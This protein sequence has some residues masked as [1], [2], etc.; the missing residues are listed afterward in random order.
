MEIGTTA[1]NV[2]TAD[3]GEVDP[4]NAGTFRAMSPGPSWPQALLEVFLCSGVP[5]QLLV[6][7]ALALAGLRP[8]GDGRFTLQLLAVLTGLDTVLLI[9]LV[10]SLLVLGGESPRR[11]L[12]GTRPILG[13][14]VRGLALVPWVFL[15]AAAVV[16][17]ISR[18]APWLVSPNPFETLARTRG[19]FVLFAIVAIV[20]GG[21]R[22][23]IQRAFILHR[24]EQRLGGA[25]VG[26]IG[27]GLLFG[28][29]HFAQ[30][31]S[32]VIVTACLGT[33]WSLVYLARRS[34]IAPMVSHASFNL[35][36][37]IAF[38]LLAGASGRP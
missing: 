17:A 37:V 3:L 25:M 20:A 31:S 4:G 10:L 1:R 9:G 38:W 15:L 13:E 28:L 34:V 5:T 22:E 32:V 12:L 6:G 18:W 2:P 7:G 30:G 14:V 36:Q 23:E 27:F 19:E 21:V 16:M 11:V 29:L 8:S 35:I 26:V 24:C 33:L